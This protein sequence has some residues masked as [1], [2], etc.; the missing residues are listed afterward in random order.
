MGNCRRLTQD[1]VK[2][3]HAEA[4]GRHIGP[5]KPWSV[6]GAACETRVP[7]RTLQSYLAGA[8]SP[9]SANA[10]KLAA[11]LGPVYVNETLEPAGLGHVCPLIVPPGADDGHRAMAA[12]ALRMNELA[13]ALIDGRLDHR[14]RRELAP[15]FK[16]LAAEL[17]LF[18]TAIGE[19]S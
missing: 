7:V 16:A 8:T 15:K 1:D 18:A 3:R 12:L 17:Q 2:A 11:L 6:E 13:D 19:G 4:L 14:E 9:L 10:L 5:R